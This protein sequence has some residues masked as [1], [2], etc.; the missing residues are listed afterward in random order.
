MF[1]CPGFFFCPRKPHPKEKKYHAIY[2]GESGIIHKWENIEG[3]DYTIPTGKLNLR[4]V[5]T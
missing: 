3:K 4:Q 2:G 1:T 5:V